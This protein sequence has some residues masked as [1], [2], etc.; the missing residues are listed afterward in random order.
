MLRPALTVG[1]GAVT[2]DLRTHVERTLG[3]AYSLEGELPGG[4]MSRV[5]VA[6]EA[7]LDREVVVKVLPPELSGQLSADRFRREIHVAAA[8]HHPHIVP[9]LAAGESGGILYYTMPRVEGES[10]RSR[11][12]RERQLPIADSL[13][14]ARDVVDALDYAH[15]HDVI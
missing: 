9:L 1:D 14:I 4:G 13:R 10:L 11:M 2:S 6:R 3:G 8:L 7:A 15:R 12:S 5:F